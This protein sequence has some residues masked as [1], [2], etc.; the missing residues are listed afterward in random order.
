[1]SRA[2]GHIC[3]HCYSPLRIRTSEGAH[4]CLRT[5]FFQ[6]TNEQCGATFRGF[7]EITHQYSP[8]AMPREGF[9]LPTPP[10]AMQE[11]D[12]RALL[13]MQARNQLDLLDSQEDLDAGELSATSRQG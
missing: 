8:S 1:M 12:R 2:F 5:L 3:G 4:I 7:V 10:K 9:A 13:A 6:C 11:A